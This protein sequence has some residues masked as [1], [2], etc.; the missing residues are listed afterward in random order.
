MRISAVGVGQDFFVA[1]DDCGDCY[2]WGLNSCGQMGQVEEED[3]SLEEFFKTP[4]KVSLIDEFEV[5]AVFTGR[6][7]VFTTIIQRPVEQTH[8][9]Q[10][11]LVGADSQQRIQQ[12]EQGIDEEREVDEHESS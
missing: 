6:A 8:A 1:A 3:E 9:P 7:C 12:Q 2:C 5:K 10:N 4:K 11:I